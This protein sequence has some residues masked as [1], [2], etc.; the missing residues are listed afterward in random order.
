MNIQNNTIAEKVENIW[1]NFLSS[2]KFEYPRKLPELLNTYHDNSIID[3]CT[4]DYLGVNSIPEIKLGLNNYLINLLKNTDINIGATGSRLL[5]GNSNS[6]IKL[7]ELIAKKKKAAKMH[8][9]L[10]VVIKQIQVF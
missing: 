5:S 9:S 1:D 6:H 8:L 10:I 4:N 3:F 7:E 2:Q